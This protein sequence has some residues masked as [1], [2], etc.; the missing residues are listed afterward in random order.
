M[1]KLVSLMAVLMSLVILAF[2]FSAGAEN[3]D[4]L[5]LQVSDPVIAYNGETVLDLS[6][7]TVQLAG[8]ATADGSIIQLF[9]DILGGGNPVTSALVQFD[10]NGLAG[11]MG[12]MSQAYGVPM[13]LIESAMSEF[14]S[15]LEGELD[16]FSAVSDGWTLPDDLAGL[17]SDYLNENAVVGE[18]TPCEVE[19]S[20]GTAQG[21]RT[22]I[23]ANI[24]ALIPQIAAALDADPVMT[25]LLAIMDE[26]AGLYV[27]S[28]SELLDMDGADLQLVCGIIS[29]DNFSGTDTNVAI[30]MD[31]EVLNINFCALDEQISDTE[32]IGRYT[33]TMAP[34]DEEYAGQSIYMTADTAANGDDFSLAAHAGYDFG[35]GE[36]VDISLM[37]SLTDGSF[38]AMLSDSTGVINAYCTYAPGN[39]AVSFNVDGEEVFN[40]YGNWGET[41]V[42]LG[43]SGED[44]GKLD[45]TFTPEDSDAYLLKGAL[46]ISYTDEYGESYDIACNLGVAPGSV[47]TANTYISPDVVVDITTLDDD[48][49]SAIEEEF[50]TVMQDCLPSLMQYVPGLQALLN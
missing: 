22:E 6:G 12:G 36:A 45:I 44:L 40:A 7:L 9:L 31:Y 13:E 27:D 43:M 23:S 19:L 18:E 2:P 32:S 25:Q 41:G 37:C 34:E 11:Y 42:S 3:I 10:S 33:M 48:Q 46:G 50:F 39:L 38:T 24:T 16:T 30:S 35:D 20:T 1:K 4:I 49:I 8:G 15:S 14:A 21:M 29:G 47:D 5:A 17:V 26:E 28:W